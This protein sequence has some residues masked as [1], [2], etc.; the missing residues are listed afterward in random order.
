MLSTGTIV[1]TECPGC[2]VPDVAGFSRKRRMLQSRGLHPS[3]FRYEK[4][5][6][7]SS[8]Q[9]VA[10]R[11]ALKELEEATCRAFACFR[12]SLLASFTLSVRSCK[13]LGQP[14]PRLLGSSPPRLLARC[15]P[16]VWSLECPQRV[17]WSLF[18]RCAHSQRK[19]PQ[20]I[21]GNRV[22]THNK[23]LEG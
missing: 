1:S 23:S 6:P 15:P 2:D 11:S 20:S 8:Q 10:A 17:H 18:V 14:A 3:M 5:V 19:V 12:S 16:R 4:L 22:P 9:Q 7:L 13:V 21:L